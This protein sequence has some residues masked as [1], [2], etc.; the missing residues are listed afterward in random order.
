M[1]YN[2]REHLEDNINAIEIAFKVSKENRKATDQE[3]AILRK[4]SGFGGIKA[5]LLP[6]SNE[7][8]LAG[9]TKADQ[10]LFPLVK[11]LYDTLKN[12]SASEMEFKGYVSTIKNSI[13]SAFYTPQPVVQSIADAIS[14][15]GLKVDRF[16]DP[17]AGQGAFV[18]SFS[19]NNNEI[20]AVNF[21]KE[22]ITGKI[23]SALHPNVDVHIEGF[24]RISSDF[25]NY[26]DVVSSNIP[27]GDVKVFDAGYTR[28]EDEVKRS[29][30]N[31]I[32]N[33]F[34]AKGLD[35]LREGGVLA[36]ITSQ[37]VMNSQQNTQIREMLLSKA[38]LISAVR[39][40]N[41]LFSENAGTDVGSD[42]IILQKDSNKQVLSEAERRFIQSELRPT[43]VSWNR[44]FNNLQRVVH[45]SWKQDTDPYGKPAIIFTHKDGEQGVA[46]QL[47][48]ILDFDFS[49]NLNVDLF[50]SNS[51]TTSYVKPEEPVIVTPVERILEE[52]VHGNNEEPKKELPTLFGNKTPEVVEQAPQKERPI[53]R[54]F[55]GEVLSHYKKGTIVIDGEDLGYISS[56][57]R[58]VAMFTPLEVNTRQEA[59]LRAY[60]PLRDTYYKLFNFEAANLVEDYASRKELNNL[61]DSFVGKHKE[62]N[63]RLNSKLILTDANG[64]DMLGLERVQGGEISKSDIFSHPVAFSIKKDDIVISN[65]T[66]AL[67]ASLNQY[68]QVNLPYM[69]EVLGK[70]SAEIIDDLKETIF[71]NP[72]IDNYEIKD[73]FVAGNVI[74]KSEQ[75]ESYL[76]D[77]PA[78]DRSKLSLQVLKD[79][80]PERIG[81][82]E[83]DFN[84]GERWIPIELYQRYATELFQTDVSISYSESLD[85]FS[86]KANGYNAIIYDK[87]CVRA[88]N[89]R[90]YNGV[91]LLENAL[92]NT[93]PDI[94]KTVMID[95][96]EVKMR[97]SDAI[98]LA[99]TKI[100]EIR[101]GFTD[102]LMDQP[103]ALQENLTDMYNRKFNCF[104][105]PSYDGSHQ[106]FPNL[107]LRGLGIPDLYKS[108]KDAVWMLLQNGGG[109][110]D[111]EV[112]TGKTLIMCVA[113]YEM[114]RLGL[115]NKPMII[116]LKANVHEIAHNYQTAYPDAKILYPTKNDF[117]PE[118]RVKLFNDIKNNDWDV[119]IL[120]HD[121]FGKIPQ[122]PEIQSEIL[123]KEL[124]SVEENLDALREQGGNISRAMLKGLEKRKANLE[125]KLAD[126]AH[127]IN[128][129][130]DDVVDFKQMGIDHIFVDESHK[131]KNLMFNTR[132]SR[133]A[134]LGSQD[135]SQ[136]A[137]NMLFALRTIQDKTG[138]DLGATFLSGTTISNSL[139]E[140]Y[141]LFKYLRPNELERQ[142][143]NCFDA[144]AAIF[145]KK[146]T[147]FEFSV[148]NN[149]VQKERFRYFIKVPEL[150]A[151][152]N[153]IT[154]YRTAKD[155][156][157]DRPEANEILH[158]IKPTPQ[159]EDFIQ[160]LMQFAENGDATILGREPL[161]QTEEKAKMLI[162]TDYAR[163]MAL[164]MRMID[165]YY[166]DH[167]DNKA[168]HCAANIARYYEQYD[169]QKGT[170]FVFSDLGTYKPD[171]WNVYS[172]IK[173]KLVENY[174]IPAEE[175]Q[176][177]QQHKSETARKKVIAAM[178]EG[179]VRIIFGSTDMLGTGVNAQQRAVAVHHLDSPWR[180]S[181]L[182]QRDGRAIRKGNEVAKL[183][184][185]NKVD[186]IIYAVEKSLD[187]YKFNLLHNK[188]TF[189]TQLKNGALGARTID[190]GNL[191]EKSGMNF[192]EYMAI[193][194]GNTDLLDKA[195]IEK[196]IVALE[197]ERKA[198]GKQKYTSQVALQTHRTTYESNN[199]TTRDM[200]ADYAHYQANLKFDNNGEKI[201]PITIN[202]VEGD[203]IKD[204]A[205][206]LHDIREF[207]RTNGEYRKVGELFGFNLLVKTEVAQG[208]DLFSD[209]PSKVQN[210]F[211][212]EGL[213]G[214]KYNFNGG[215]LA[216]DP[217]LATMNFINALD[218][219]PSLIEQYE[220][221]NAKIE[222][223][224]PV[225][226]EVVAG[227]WKKEDE[228]KIAKAE[229]AIIDRKI[230]ATI[231]D[232]GNKEITTED[233]E[234][235]DALLIRFSNNN[236][237]GEE[238]FYSLEERQS[239]TQKFGI[240]D[241]Y[242]EAVSL[243]IEGG[244]ENIEKAEGLEAEMAISAREAL[245]S[246]G[247]EIPAPLTK[248][249]KEE[250]VRS[251]LEQLGLNVEDIDAIIVDDIQEENKLELIV[252][253]NSEM[254]NDMRSN[255]V[256]LV[257]VGEQGLV[258][259]Q[260]K[261][262]AQDGYFV[263]DTPSNKKFLQDN[264][265]T[266]FKQAENQRHLFVPLRA[267]KIASLLV[268]SAVLGPIGGLAVSIILNQTGLLD[269]MVNKHL[270]SSD[271]AQAMKK[272][273]TVKATNVVDGKNVE[274]Y[275]YLDK[276]TGAV[277]KINVND[278][279]IPNKLSG[280]QLTPDQ[281]EK[282]KDGKTIEYVAN[283]TY[284]AARI[285]MN[286]PNGIATFWKEMKS[287]VDY[288]E[289]PSVLSSD[290]EKLDYIAHKG[291]SGVTDIYGG[292]EKNVERD[293]FLQKFGLQDKYE[294]AKTAQRNMSAGQGAG[295]AQGA[296]AAQGAAG[297]NPY[298][299]VAEKVIEEFKNAVLFVAD[300]AL[301]DEEQEKSNTYRR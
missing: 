219:I 169:E 273:L 262:V 63:A 108:Q 290:K 237:V 78:D 130:T 90:T 133:V 18:D 19:R 234:R 168:S 107:D 178:N 142:N 29:A 55:T 199:S 48:R 85:D 6:Y 72:L 218:K 96:K 281:M 187:S 74:E 238:N 45:T 15:R 179:K 1:A 245:H 121:Q 75:I 119:V 284:M 280:L 192:S 104:V 209:D 267:K 103:Q 279:R 98:Q 157:V 28:S 223:D 89:G 143:I 217:K 92:I 180:P 91:A 83:L 41:N 100:E 251:E 293:S 47:S 21:E 64:R 255:S 235:E 243:R 230:Q 166:E 298:L 295:T 206:R 158:N 105:R 240:E 289:V 22:N 300:M 9:W 151:F 81:F 274:Q 12:N 27:F 30:A 162:A 247:I 189:I 163:K 160:R 17:S 186:V 203:D 5:I 200:R 256:A 140:L 37:G 272:G 170:Q 139:T 42:L 97:D 259:V 35:T 224:I 172:E 122:S 126:I 241:K 266:Y 195:K 152:Y 301:S 164:D 141:L 248:D 136:K 23:L 49:R 288:K 94:S 216:K 56:V 93:V 225:L 265:I 176:F 43:G 184:A 253:G 7:S 228:L 181:D 294:E 34:F 221:R 159:Q 10:P 201:N 111:H 263:E 116:G 222:V 258:K 32:H 264:D 242:N 197:S 67:S 257:P 190:E 215:T 185:N 213:T 156:G 33:Y 137:L 260:G 8:D 113:A 226:E 283:N 79:N 118:N 112:G 14:N 211:M 296:S 250:A 275:M 127:S 291:L 131:F 69:E 84:F 271:Q 60:V 135:G 38:H 109:I 155:V 31:T 144:W 270:L 232:K 208:A 88:A 177:I 249:E 286:K 227:K 117:S 205:S 68:G 51:Q 77:N 39:L 299:A 70:S 26:F 58:S 114:K 148:T 115:V 147:D 204:L 54:A 167:I 101:N 44:Y 24:E 191:D 95:G 261:L 175:I 124:D 87:F 239:F 102:W 292:V 171:Q 188:Q 71:Y 212:I 196:R 61:Y 25:D 269:K 146:S 202:G 65:S 277:N 252:D 198:F 132:H 4:Y 282:L 123:Q 11:K 106:T 182:A 86:V 110:A 149:I 138:K 268:A 80:Y 134:G 36:F 13:L 285:D 99:N 2:K 210:K 297:A 236:R 57:S 52:R 150:A 193:L 246:K 231:T 161:S 220:A 76:L 207:V 20:Q 254:A 153:E 154:D 128:E 73:R 82:E 129:R 62:F 194:S 229:L 278:V 16:L 3:L 59:K 233:M 50:N 125:V 165:P 173:Q 46:Q 183:Y 214:I 145:A 244:A 66:E 287:D 120:T 276:D 40:P 53:E 174:N